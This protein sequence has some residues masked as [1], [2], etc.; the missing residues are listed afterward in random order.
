MKLKEKGPFILTMVNQFL[1]VFN[2]TLNTIYQEKVYEIKSTGGFAIEFQKHNTIN[3][4]KTYE[5]VKVLQCNIQARV[6]TFSLDCK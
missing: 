2:D 3:K 5:A 4:L 1:K 6:L